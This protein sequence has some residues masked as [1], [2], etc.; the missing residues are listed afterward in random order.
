MSSVTAIQMQSDWMD[1]KHMPCIMFKSMVH[2][3]HCNFWICKNTY[4][5]DNLTREANNFPWVSVQAGYK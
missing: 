1:T 4:A 5:G 2:F 3:L